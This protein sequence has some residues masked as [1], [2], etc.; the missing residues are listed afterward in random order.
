MSRRMKNYIHLTVP[1]YFP[2]AIIASF[3]GIGTSGGTINYDVV[4]AFVSLTFLVG[5]F[6]AF[7]GVIDLEIDSISKPRRPLPSGGMPAR[8]ALIYTAI[9]YVL[10]LLVAY[11]LTKQFF[12]I[13]IV[14]SIVTIFYSLPKIRLKKHFLL[15]NLTG[16]IFYGLLCPLSGWALKPYNPIPINFLGF[17]FLFSLSLSITKDLE[18]ISGDRTYSVKTIPVALGIEKAIQIVS[19][20]LLFSFVYLILLII[21]NFIAIKFV[22]SL[23]VLPAF[24]YLIQKTNAQLKSRVRISIDEFAIIRKMFL[25]LIGL[26]VLAGFL[27]GII[28]FI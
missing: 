13:T 11:L 26:G 18:D 20:L 1:Y 6:N 21:L 14:S 16:A 12:I 28:A 23:I 15:S 8:N 22:L 19:M 7:N 25:M 17:T 2:I 10:A 5:G 4:L 27:I 24:L 9:L 3:V